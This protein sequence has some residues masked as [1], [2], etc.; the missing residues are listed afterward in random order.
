MPRRMTRSWDLGLAR[1]AFFIQQA[2]MELDREHSECD[3]C[4]YE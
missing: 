2:P 4:T 1:K 3:Y